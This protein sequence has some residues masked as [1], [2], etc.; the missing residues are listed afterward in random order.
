MANKKSQGSNLLQFAL[1]FAVVYLGSQF[2]LS[3]FFPDQFGNQPAFTGVRLTVPSV[4]VGHHPVATV[5]NR[6]G[7]GIVLAARCPQPPVDVYLV[8]V[9]GTSGKKVTELRASDVVLPCPSAPLVIANGAKGQINLQPWKYSLFEQVGTYE[10][11]LPST[12]STPASG[13]GAVQ[14]GTARFELKE[15]GTF[16]KLF[17]TF[18]LSPLLNLLILIASLLPGHN[19]GLAIILITLIIKLVLYI[20]TKH[21]LEGQKKMQMLQPKIEALK[22]KYPNDAKK[23]QE[24]TM[25]LWAE[26]KI[27]PFQSCLPTLVQ[28][29]VL[30]GLY[31]AVQEGA[32]L[33][34]SRHLIYPA[35]QH[36]SWT[37]GTSFLGLDLLKPE[38][39]ILPPL[40]VV[41]QF[42]QM[43]LAFAIQARKTKKAQKEEIIDVPTPEEKHHKKPASAQDMQQRVMMY[44]LPLMIGFM[45]I[46]FPAAVGLYWGIS[47]LFGIGQQVLVNR[48]HLRV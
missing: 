28:L 6:T 14:A 34:T 22:Q 7:T 47:T 31:Y 27:N 16:T 38:W 42:L 10:V 13:T 23:L 36:L 19:L 4:T 9:E 45:A 30:I 37:F 2:V 40:L 21:A 33:E 41:L 44:G 43:K 15:P 18:I 46:Q 39:Y 5:E 24:E 29:P 17:R 3:T 26:H 11:R 8:D 35:Y 12:V 48:E 25:K 20:P 32:A 1:I